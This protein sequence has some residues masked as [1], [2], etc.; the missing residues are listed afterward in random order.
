MPVLDSLRQMA[1]E[2]I[3]GL[4][5]GTIPTGAASDDA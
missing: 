4:L 3:D 5:D 2:T 1:I